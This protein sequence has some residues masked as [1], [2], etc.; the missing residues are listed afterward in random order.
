MEMENTDMVLAVSSLEPDCAWVQRGEK[1]VRMG[2]EK[3]ALELPGTDFT[4]L[5]EKFEQSEDFLAS[6]Q[7]LTIPKTVSCYRGKECLSIQLSLIH[8]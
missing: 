1:K 7:Y 4:A 6:D 3:I 2:W 5:P 8:I